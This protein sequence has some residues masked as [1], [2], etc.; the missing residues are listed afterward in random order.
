MK[1]DLRAR[2]GRPLRYLMMRLFMAS[3]P[4]LG[5]AHHSGSYSGSKAQVRTV[6]RH[7]ID[8]RR[9]PSKQ[10]RLLKPQR[11][12]P[13]SYPSSSP[14]RVEEGF[15]YGVAT[16]LQFVISHSSSLFTCLSSPLSSTPRWVVR[17]ILPR[18]L[19]SLLSHCSHPAMYTLDLYFF[20][21]PPLNQARS[22]ISPI[23]GRH[24]LESLLSDI[25]RWVNTQVVS[26]LSSSP[27]PCISP[28]TTRCH[29]DGASRVP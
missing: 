1:S 17:M 24:L 13:P 19:T 16:E 22:R 14:C 12:I 6:K 2:R 18:K 20:A 5:A 23:P 7:V 11:F 15:T 28:F 25:S 26:L 9:C 29:A 4:S 21:S 8:S 3:L 10:C 27:S